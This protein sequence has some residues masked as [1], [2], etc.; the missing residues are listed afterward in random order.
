MDWKTLG[1][2]IRRARR[3]Q[4]LT[5][6]KLAEIVGVHHITISR[7][8]NGQMPGVTLALIVKLSEAL[9]LSMDDLI[10]DLETAEVSHGWEPEGTPA[11]ALTPELV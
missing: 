7:I 8:E 6:S 2:K 11:E 3:D 9:N 5:Q 10:S 1:R 4:D